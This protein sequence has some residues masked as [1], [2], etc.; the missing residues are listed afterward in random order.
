MGAV[1]VVLILQRPGQLDAQRVGLLALGQP[2][3]DDHHQQ[4]NQQ[5]HDDLHI[6]VH[7]QSS[8]V[9]Q[10]IH[11]NRDR[12]DD[13]Q[14]QAH[15][16]VIEIVRLGIHLEAAQG[17]QPLRRH[18]NQRHDEHA[19]SLAAPAVHLASSVEVDRELLRQLIP[20]DDARQHR[21]QGDNGRDDQRL[22]IF[23]QHNRSL[24]F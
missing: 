15:H 6:H 17:A 9:H 4:T 24:S 18:Q 21:Q 23:L 3:A 10:R 8:A 22:A 20:Q 2:V 1:P 16:L 7:T 14:H 5:R 13:P 12:R 19:N 11:Q